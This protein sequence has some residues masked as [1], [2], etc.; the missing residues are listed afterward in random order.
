MWC[1]S[2]IIEQY[3]SRFLQDMQTPG[4]YHRTRSS[5]VRYYIRRA[6]GLF[7]A[8]LPQDS[9]MCDRASEMFYFLGVFLAKTLQDN[10]SGP[11]DTQW[12]VSL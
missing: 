11:Q 6:G 10:R 3:S 1:I 7:P 8:P 4:S 2:F 5:F 12:H 9:S